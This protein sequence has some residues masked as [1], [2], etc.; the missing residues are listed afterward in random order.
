MLRIGEF[1]KETGLT[2]KALR[3]YEKRQLIKPYWI[4]RYTGYRYYNENQVCQVAN[5]IQ[6]KNMGFPLRLIRTLLQPNI[7][8]AERE[9]LL[10]EQRAALL[11]D[12]AL[13]EERLRRLD[14][15]IQQTIPTQDGIR[16]QKEN[17]MEL[18]IKS[19]PKLKVA[20]LLYT[21]KNQ[22]NEIT[23]L[24]D[25]FN[26]RGAELC[27]ADAMV[28]YGVCRVPPG[29]EDGVFEYLAGVDIQEGRPLPKGAV[30][31]EVPACEVAVF[32]H[33]GAKEGLRDTY[34]R[35]YTEWLPASDYAPMEAGLDMEVYTEEFTY[36]APNS[37]MY[38]YVP[39]VK[40]NS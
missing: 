25:A 28:V 27:P 40:K 7:I 2:V 37:V 18:E 1:A 10:T 26:R 8:S 39:V 14:T 32:K 35:I 22:H 30:V 15:Y 5:I 3:L 16:L 31:R 13:D 29:L 11:Q 17:A 34:A 12:I 33:L 19:L 20:G 4:D 23:Q 24:W 36:F 38:I 9:R 6:L 21:G